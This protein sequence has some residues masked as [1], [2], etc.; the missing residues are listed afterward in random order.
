MAQIMGCTKTPMLF[1]NEE[2]DALKALMSTTDREVERL[3][4][5]D[6]PTVVLL[7][8]KVLPSPIGG[9]GRSVLAERVRGGKAASSY[10]SSM[11]PWV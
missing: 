2:L 6:G 5:D 3:G 7:R 10:D 4:I 8:S 1:V 11:P 9:R